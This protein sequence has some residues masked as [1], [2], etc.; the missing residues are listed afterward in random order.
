MPLPPCSGAIPRPVPFVQDALPRPASD[1]PCC[2]GKTLLVVEDSRQ[3][4]DTLRLM[5]MRLG[6]RMRR[7]ASLAEARSH[8]SLYRPDAVLVDLGLPDGAGESLIADLALNPRRPGR[9]VA[10]SAYP[11]RGQSALA[12]GADVFLQKPLPSLAVI[13]AALEPGAAPMAADPAGLPPADPQA[14]IDDLEQ[15]ATRLSGLID[16]QADHPKA[17]EEGAYLAAFLTGLARQTADAP[18]AEAVAGWHLGGDAAALLAVI[19]ARQAGLA[20]RA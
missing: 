8:L 1:L 3:A 9:I 7:A 19:R 10:L 6:G 11:E 17:Q 2:Q 16:A 13:G 15:A 14:V 4:A 12:C 20:A 18:L 5:L